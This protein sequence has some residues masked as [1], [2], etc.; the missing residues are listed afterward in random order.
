MALRTDLADNTPAATVHADQHNE[1]NTAVLALQAGGST[2]QTVTYTTSSLAV[3]GENQGSVTLA[4]SYRLLQVAVSLAARVRLYDRAAKQTAD[5]TRQIGSV[6]T[7]DHGVVCDFVCTTGL[8][9]V[10]ATPPII[11]SSM[12]TTPSTSIPITVDNLSGATSTGI[13][14]T[15]IFFVEE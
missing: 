6:P 1:V 13:S 15:L 14:V 9:T 2:R 11:G 8:L 12:E 10:N 5:A 4:K 7:G 3:S